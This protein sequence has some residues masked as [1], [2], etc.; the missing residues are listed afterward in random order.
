MS[1]KILIPVFLLFASTL[2]SQEKGNLKITVTH[3]NSGQNAP[4]HFMLFN[5]SNGFPREKELALTSGKS[6]PKNSQAEFIFKNI[7]RGKYAVAVFMDKNE[8]GK[9]D[10]NFIGFPKEPIGTY[11][12][13]KLGKPSFKKASF[14]L[15]GDFKEIEIK[16]LNQ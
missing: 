9:I 7:P 1:T 8:N 3:I 10:S 15:T 13:S 2:L 4:I 11:N 16:L 6:I 12:M 5:N 14:E